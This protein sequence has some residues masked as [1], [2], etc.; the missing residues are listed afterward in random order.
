MVQPINK[1]NPNYKLEGEYCPECLIGQII[2]KNGPYSD[3]LACDRYPKCDFISSA[4]TE[5]SSDDLEHQADEILK[6]ANQ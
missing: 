5:S 3:F 1:Q 2:K 4:K 6:N